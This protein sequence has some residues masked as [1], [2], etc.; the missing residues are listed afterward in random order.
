MDDLVDSMLPALKAL[1]DRP[2][3]L[4]GYSV[5]GLIAFACA[6]RLLA[7]GHGSLLLHLVVAASCPPNVER[8]DQHVCSLPDADFIAYVCSLDGLPREVAEDRDMLSFL[9]P[10]LRADFSLGASF[11]RSDHDKIDLPI[12]AIGGVSDRT[13]TPLQLERW[14]QMTGSSCDVHLLEGGHFFIN[15][16][17]DAL[18]SAVNEV[19]DRY[20]GAAAIVAVA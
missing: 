10:I 5:G 17:R 14:K 13:A 9:T 12:T 4:F 6:S 16:N 7:D 20:R 2:T 3:I 1:L 15:S 11:S 18:I 19:V 8:L